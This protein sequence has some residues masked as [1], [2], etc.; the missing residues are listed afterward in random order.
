MVS[1]K[2]RSKGLAPV[3]SRNPLRRKLFLFE[4]R[5]SSGDEDGQTRHQAAIVAPVPALGNAACQ[6]GTNSRKLLGLP[7]VPVHATKGANGCQAGGM[8]RI[9]VVG[10]PFPTK[11]LDTCIWGK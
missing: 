8:P 6:I 10:T 11:F 4:A 9:T 3:A 5:L 7:Q 1:S 2:R